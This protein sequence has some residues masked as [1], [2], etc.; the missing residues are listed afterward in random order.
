MKCLF[1]TNLDLKEH[2]GI[3]KKIISE[4]IALSKLMGTCFF[5]QRKNLGSKVITIKNGKIC[6]EIE[7]SESIFDTTKK[8][9][10]D[11]KIV[12]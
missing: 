6:Y 3:Y 1:L 2:E 8:I 4:A 9:V 7:Y 12:F 11:N 5:V 10:K